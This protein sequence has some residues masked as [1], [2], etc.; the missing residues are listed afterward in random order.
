MAEPNDQSDDLSDNRPSEPRSK[1][2]PEDLG[3]DLQAL[4]W[5]RSSDHPD[6]LEVAFTGEW[7]LMRQANDESG[8]VL[9]Y[10]HHEWEC[11]LDGARKGEF[12]PES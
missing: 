9:V 12:D 4:P 7:V 6:A 10:D 8:T 5:R 11:F 3:V 2:R 1:P